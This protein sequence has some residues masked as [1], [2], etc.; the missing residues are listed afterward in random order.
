MKTHTHAH[1]H[2]LLIQVGRV[3]SGPADYYSSQLPWKQR[4]GT[5]VDELLSSEE[6]RRYHRNKYLQLQ[7]KFSSGT[8]RLRNIK[9]KRKYK[10]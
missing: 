2:W 1:T 5:L 10:L 8:K 9:H 6:S 3:E 4:K 7:S